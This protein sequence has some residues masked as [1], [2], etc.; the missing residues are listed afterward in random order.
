M[1]IIWLQFRKQFLNAS[2]TNKSFLGL[3]GLYRSLRE[4]TQSAY[5]L[6]HLRAD[7]KSRT[8]RSTEGSRPL[9]HLAASLIAKCRDDEATGPMNEVN[10]AQ[11]IYRPRYSIP[12]VQL[13][14]MKR[15]RCKL[16]RLLF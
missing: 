1:N 6:N 12:I 13:S 8:D 9:Q 10:T 14:Q 2:A 5:R 15:K 4:R 16:S 3:P 7:R 11:S